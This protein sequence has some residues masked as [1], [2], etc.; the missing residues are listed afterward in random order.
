MRVAIFGAGA[1]GGYFGGRLAQAGEDVVLIARG[2]HL[3]A[4]QTHGLRVDSVVGDFVVDP[5]AATDDPTAVGV[6]DAI[7]VSVK[8]WQVPQV[9]ADMRPMVGPETF[10]VPLENGVEAPSQL[11][12]V[13]GE[14]HVLGGL[15]RIISALAEPGHVRHTGINPTITFGEL[16]GRHTERAQRLRDAFQR[17]SGV[18]PEVAPDIRAAMWEKFL[19]I[20]SFS[21][22]AAV[23]RAPVGI[24]RSLP[25]TRRMLEDAM[26]EIV[27]V[28]EALDIALPQEAVGQTMAFIDSLPREGT[29]SMQRDVMA[30]H[31]SE[32]EAQNGAVVRLG[33]E[34]GVATPL[35]T[36]I[37]HSLLPQELE[38]RGQLPQT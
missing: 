3:R 26:R 20:A 31:P 16:D 32:L 1:V 28:A 7:L 38:A 21:G 5:V 22:L 23:T 30:G 18:T 15:C 12:K 27:A 35:H 37:Y 17:A 24:L 9:A 25:A 11:A 6:V 34:A 33:Q 36:F 19:F 2:E 29:A 8:A 10:V 13:L 4:L 14:R